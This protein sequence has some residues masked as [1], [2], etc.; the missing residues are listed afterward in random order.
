[1]DRDVVV[2][3]GWDRLRKAME[4]RARFDDQPS[5]HAHDLTLDAW[6]IFRRL[7]TSQAHWNTTISERPQEEFYCR[8]DLK[9]ILSATMYNGAI[10]L[11]YIQLI[12]RSPARLILRQQYS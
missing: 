11:Q 4:R 7:A 5:V 6:R 3:A 1:M 9:S 10:G 2:S 8:G 12:G